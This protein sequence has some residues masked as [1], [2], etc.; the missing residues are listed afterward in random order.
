MARGLHGSFI[1]SVPGRAY[2]RI[3]PGNA[4]LGLHPRRVA[5]TPTVVGEP[6]HDLPEVG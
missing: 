4:F 2:V 1:Y 5:D 6:Q 3:E